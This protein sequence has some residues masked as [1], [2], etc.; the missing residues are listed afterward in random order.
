MY[1]QG[2]CYLTLSAHLIAPVLVLCAC[3]QE[4]GY[5]TADVAE[6]EGLHKLNL[7]G[8]KFRQMLRNGEGK[9]SRREGKQGRRSRKKVGVV[10]N[11][12]N[13]KLTAGSTPSL[14][15][16]Y[17]LPCCRRRHPGVVCLQVRGEGAAGGTAGG[18]VSPWQLMELAWPS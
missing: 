5:V 1:I 17:P 3:L 18:S 9:Q 12:G 13:L 10:A 14:L 6:K 2:R 11:L 7:S 8:T 15:T 16:R 4:K